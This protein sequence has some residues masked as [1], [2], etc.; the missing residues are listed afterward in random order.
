M[1]TGR[2]PG[3]N[4]SLFAVHKEDPEDPDTW[5]VVDFGKHRIENDNVA[6]AA[7]DLREHFGE[8]KKNLEIITQNENGKGSKV[9]ATYNPEKR[10]EL[11]LVNLSDG[12]IVPDERQNSEREL[13][14]GEKSDLFTSILFASS[15]GA[16]GVVKEDDVKE[17]T[18]YM[19]GY[20]EPGTVIMVTWKS[21]TYNSVVVA[22]A[23]QGYFEVPVPE[24]LE[25]GDHTV[26]VY[27][28]NKSNKRASNYTQLFFN[29]VF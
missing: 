22:D 1:I 10:V 19:S 12:E 15:L 8:K 25:S 17:E 11:E 9:R 23:S 20:A 21:L 6:I 7:V 5:Q 18:R 27:S 24:E 4:V 29:K 26:L 3:E 16:D 13:K 14:P 28:Y 2:T